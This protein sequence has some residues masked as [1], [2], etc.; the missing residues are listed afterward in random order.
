[1]RW[2]RLLDYGLR[3]RADGLPVQGS[4]WRRTAAGGVWRVCLDGLDYK[5]DIVAGS[6]HDGLVKVCLTWEG[7]DTNECEKF[8]PAQFFK[9]FEP[10]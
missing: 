3:M 7:R 2:E 9:L 5:G 6:G 4:W 10:A 8:E 1:M